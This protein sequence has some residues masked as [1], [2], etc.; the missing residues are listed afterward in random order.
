MYCNVLYTQH[1]LKLLSRCGPYDLHLSAREQISAFCVNA[2]IREWI[3]L[4][5]QKFTHNCGIYNKQHT[6]MN[7]PKGVN[8]P[9][10]CDTWQKLTKWKQIKIRWNWQKFTI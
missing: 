3:K 10:V 2:I 9:L 8:V 5:H 4:H 6:K 1:L 7:I